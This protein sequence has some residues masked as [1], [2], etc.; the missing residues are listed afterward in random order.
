M[1]A[2]TKAKARTLAD[3][4]AAHDQSVIVPNKLRTALAQLQAEGGDENWEY[5][6]DFLRRA[7]VS[8]SVIGQYRDQFATH[9]ASVRVSTHGGGFKRIWIATTKAA[10]KFRAVTGESD[11]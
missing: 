5:E 11:G 3:F 1:N 6:S 10:A 9:I 8:N 2:K 7:G 4:R